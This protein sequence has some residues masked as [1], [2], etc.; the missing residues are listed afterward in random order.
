MEEIADKKISGY[1]K[2]AKEV[3]EIKGDISKL[4]NDYQMHLIDQIIKVAEM[5][6]REEHLLEEAHTQKY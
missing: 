3:M 6:Q 4:N 1:I 5:I 2:R